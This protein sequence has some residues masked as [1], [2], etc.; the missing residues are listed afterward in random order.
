MTIMT[1]T[2]FGSETITNW[3]GFIK[4]HKMGMWKS[5]MEMR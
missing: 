5:V 4:S 2:K 1:L 3:M